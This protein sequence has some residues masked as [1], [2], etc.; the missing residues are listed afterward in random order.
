MEIEKLLN[1]I[2]IAPYYF[3]EL[4]KKISPDVAKDTFQKL[5]NSGSLDN[6]I[7]KI[8][9]I[10][11]LSELQKEIN[12]FLLKQ[13]K[14]IKEGMA[15]NLITEDVRKELDKRLKLIDE[16]KAEFIN[17]DDFRNSFLS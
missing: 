13:V 12:D 5:L 1:D 4:G 8:A 14:E 17:Y 11:Y 3:A 15:E 9:R 10:S 2:D 16:G 6:R 7:L